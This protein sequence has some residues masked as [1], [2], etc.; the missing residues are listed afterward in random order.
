MCRNYYS[1][2]HLCEQKHKFK[3]RS[4]AE[5]NQQCQNNDRLTQTQTYQCSPFD[6]IVRWPTLS[7]RGQVLLGQQTKEDSATPT[8]RSHIQQSG[9]CIYTAPSPFRWETFIRHLYDT[10]YLLFGMFIQTTYSYWLSRVMKLPDPLCV[11]CMDVNMFSQT[12]TPCSSCRRF[13]RKAQ[14]FKAIQTL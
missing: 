13:L 10:Y 5:N 1:V 3:Q 4:V 2:I 11:L 12:I 9:P 8:A 6:S 14:F 7:L